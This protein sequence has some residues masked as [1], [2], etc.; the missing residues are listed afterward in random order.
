MK[1]KYKSESG[2]AL[3]TTILVTVLLTTAII[4]L[5]SAAGNHSKNVTDV[6]SETKAY[7]AAESGLQATI[8]V[9]R[10]DDDVNYLYADANPTLSAKL[11]YN[12]PTTGTANRIVIGEAANTYNPKT[13]TA[14]SITVEDPDNTADALTYYTS[15][16][17]TEYNVSDKFTFSTDRK[18]IYIC[19]DAPCHGDG[20]VSTTPRTLITFNDAPSTNVGFTSGTP[21]NQLLG[22]FTATNENGGVSITGEIRFRVDYYITFPRSGLRNMRGS[23]KM[24][25]GSL[26]VTFDSPKYELLG[27]NLE[28]CS[29]PSETPDC[30]DVALNL[31]VT[32]TNNSFYGNM[33]SVEPYRLRV[34]STGYGPNGAKKVLEAFVQKNFFNDFSSP[35]PLMM[36]GPGAELVFDPGNSSVFEIN[37]VDS[38]G[39]IVPSVGVIDQDGLDNVIDGIPDNNDNIQ[40]KPEIVT[41][42]PDWMATPQNLDALISQLRQTA[43]NS[44]RYF[45]NPTSNLTNVGDN[46]TGTGITFCEGDCTAGVD[47]GG[48][49]VV[50]GQL[51]NVGDFDFKGLIIIT[52][53]EGWLRN[54]G[55][56]GTLEGNVIIAPY[57]ASNLISNTFTL[58]PKYEVTGGGTSDITYGTIDFDVTFNGTK[59]ISNFVLGIAEK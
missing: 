50:T 8:N 9:L 25:G 2:A 12:Y 35:A 10:N 27:S 59:A 55:G 5:L 18:T 6:L 22:S 26:T 37:G 13:G 44:G 52:G 43:I 4:A 46:A 42:V 51:T 48:I 21:D 3:A 47:G 53:E 24:S 57:N 39:I 23:I 49:L 30:A 38:D 17:F 45:D 28:L 19:D 7:Y 15:G 34:L 40:P 14:Y 20:Y 31:S 16:A 1:N 32:P 36:Q 11:P 33:T 58:P 54:G 29:S 41:D 56:N